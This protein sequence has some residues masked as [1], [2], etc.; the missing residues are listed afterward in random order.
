MAQNTSA[1]VK[2]KPEVRENLTRLKKIEAYIS[3]M[4]SLSTTVAKVLEVC[5]SPTA[6][7]NELNR[8]ISLDPVLTGRVLTV[9]NS[10][11][12]GLPRRVTLLTRAIIMLGLNTVKNLALS[13]AIL[14]SLYKRA[15]FKALSIE[16][17]WTHSLCVGVGAKSLAGI[18][19]IPV[20]QR[21]EYFVAGLLH[22]L[23]KIPLNTLFQEDYVL[24]L[25]RVREGAGPL[26]RAENRYLGID[27]G[28]VGRMI[29]E[30]WRLSS[31]MGASMWQHHDPSE[32]REENRPM[33]AMVALANGYANASGMACNMDPSPDETAY[34][35]LME[36]V[37][38]GRETLEDLWEGVQGEIENAK[39]FLKMSGRP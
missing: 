24:A 23:G 14:D 33:V 34:E 6:S 8:V 1:G 16:A 7:P 21:E 9:I 26:Y 31:G 17:F 29:A 27:H 39:V 37:G 20:A 19:G 11:Y 25:Q 2:G 35:T 13:T 15:S 36:E 30:K 18:K 3:R 22:D 28:T 32:A 38:V 10:T 5:N 12:Y 4:P